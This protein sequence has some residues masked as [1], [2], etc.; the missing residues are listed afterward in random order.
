MPLTGPFAFRQDVGGFQVAVITVVSYNVYGARHREALHEVLTRLAPD[1]LV[2]NEA[3]KL[4][5]GWRRQCDRLARS[6]G[7]RRA[8][9]GKDAG[10]NMICVS[11]RVSVES[12]TARR[13]AQPPFAPRRGIVTAQC[14]VD[15]VQFGVVGI[16]L[17]LSGASRPAEAAEAV[18]DMGRLHGPLVL[19]GDLNERPEMACWKVFRG[20]GFVDPAEPGAFTWTA[21]DPSQRIDG[22]LVRGAQALQHVVP[23]LPSSL[24]A[25]AS[26]HLPVLARLDMRPVSCGDTREPAPSRAAPGTGRRQ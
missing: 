18:A 16:H 26:D 24:L 21:A 20:I 2:V 13:L 15:G 1:V 12:S 11:P 9:G 5:F 7:L 6:A 4:P 22:L 8:A 17:S 3:P 14:E 19:C 23:D 25:T 10:G